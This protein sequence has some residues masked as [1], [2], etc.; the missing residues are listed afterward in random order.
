VRGKNGEYGS[1]LLGTW[2]VTE[3]DARGKML[4]HLLENGLLGRTLS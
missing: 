4:I 1:A 3:A 2:E